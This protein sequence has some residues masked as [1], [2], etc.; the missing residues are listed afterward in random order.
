M[1]RLVWHNRLKP[2]MGAGFSVIR[3]DKIACE[4]WLRMANSV[5][6]MGESCPVSGTICPE[7]VP[8]LSGRR[9]GSQEERF[10]CLAGK[11]WQACGFDVVPGACVAPAGGLRILRPVPGS[12]RMVGRAS[13]PGG[14]P[15]KSEQKSERLKA[16]KPVLQ[17]GHLRRLQGYI[18]GVIE[19][20]V[21]TKPLES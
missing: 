12:G 1:K 20:W 15:W 11:M 6:K 8:G 2:W 18:M 13:G 16:T 5:Q 7:N 17:T 3:S 10:G 21:Y 14:S 9:N 4:V 19:S